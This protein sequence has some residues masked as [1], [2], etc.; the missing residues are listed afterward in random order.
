MSP[1]ELTNDEKSSVTVARPREGFAVQAGKYSL[2]VVFG[3]VLI[4]FSL[5]KPSSYGTVSNF[6]SL[7]AIN[8]PGLFV[9]LAATLPFI[10]GEF[11]LSV[12]NVAILSE[13]LFVG[14]I[15]LQHLNVFLA[16]AIALVAAA[17]V[18]L[19]NG[20]AIAVFRFSSFIVTL[21]MASL[22][23]GIFLAYTGAQT[24]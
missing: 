14:L 9:A 1:T 22:V 17:A 24:I 12:A 18:G 3:L 5:L 23:A 6:K 2:L 20:I 4:I 21:A 13:V 19:I 15:E 16:I 11:D 10:V 8:I 7:L